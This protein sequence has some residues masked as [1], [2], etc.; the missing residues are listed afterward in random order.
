VR[1][2]PAA[3]F[4]CLLCWTTKQAL[5]EDIMP[6][7]SYHNTAKALR[8]PMAPRLGLLFQLCKMATTRLSGQLDKSRG[9]RHQLAKFKL[10]SK[11]PA[12]KRV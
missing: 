10:R 12:K 8:S 1:T 11:P 6:Q 2:T 4:I 9:Q 3:V 7:T 5:A